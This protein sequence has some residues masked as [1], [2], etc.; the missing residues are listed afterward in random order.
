MA[1]L[2]IKHTHYHTDFQ[3]SIIKEEQPSAAAASGSGDLPREL[4]VCHTNA[5]LALS[6]KPRIRYLCAMLA[7]VC[8]GRQVKMYIF[9]MPAKSVGLIEENKPMKCPHDVLCFLSGATSKRTI[10]ADT[11]AH[12]G[13][14][15]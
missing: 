8:P 13:L 4:G 15:G 9:A 11:S 2:L 7:R 10:K 1:D 3:I 14:V 6:G 5:M 12:A